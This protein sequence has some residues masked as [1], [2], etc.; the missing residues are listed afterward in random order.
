MWAE[1]RK[2][3]IRPPLQWEEEG[4][5]AVFSVLGRIVQGGDAQRCTLLNWASMLLINPLIQVQESRPW[6]QHFN[7]H[8]RLLPLFSVTGTLINRIIEYDSILQTTQIR[9]YGNI[10][11]YFSA[12]IKRLW[13]PEKGITITANCNAGH[14]HKLA[15][16]SHVVTGWKSHTG[17]YQLKRW[18]KKTEQTLPGE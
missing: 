18:I 12:E 14:H 2:S 3:S 5:E 4:Q 10:K 11:L 8:L 17:A 9:L 6:Q 15:L 13:T 1:T 16:V 7:L